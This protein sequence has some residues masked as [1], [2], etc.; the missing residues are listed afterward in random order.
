MLYALVIPAHRDR[1]AALIDDLE[2]LG[3]VA[4]G[5]RPISSQIGRSGTEGVL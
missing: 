5:P 4:I 3:T 2:R 1:T